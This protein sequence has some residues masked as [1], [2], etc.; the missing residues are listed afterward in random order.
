MTGE[1]GVVDSDHALRV[2]QAEPRLERLI[3]R[4][5]GSMGTMK[6]WFCRPAP[7]GPDESCLLGFVASKNLLKNYRFYLK[8]IDSTK[9]T[10]D[11][12]QK[13]IDSTKNI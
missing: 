11:S 13:T 1:D 4:C 6:R 2:R 7:K 10:I 5:T 3:H 9:K 12:T 8:T